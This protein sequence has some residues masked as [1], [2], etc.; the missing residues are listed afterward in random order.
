MNFEILPTPEFEKEFKALYKES[1][2][3]DRHASNPEKHPIVV[4]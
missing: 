2:R 1:H 3:Q 4:R